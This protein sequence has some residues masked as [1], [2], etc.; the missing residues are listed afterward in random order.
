MLLFA[1]TAQ[2][3]LI[4][5][6]IARQSSAMDGS[7]FQNSISTRQHVTVTLIFIYTC[8]A[9]GAL[10]TYMDITLGFTVS[11]IGAQPQYFSRQL[12]SYILV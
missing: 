5:K 2:E 9:S 6:T 12:C 1:G 11:I 7:S 8:L 10:V 3:A 4:D